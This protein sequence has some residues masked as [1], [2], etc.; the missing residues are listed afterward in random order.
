VESSVRTQNSHAKVPVETK[1]PACYRDLGVV[2]NWRQLGSSTRDAFA[3]ETGVLIYGSAIRVRR[4]T[5]ACRH[6][7]ISNR[8]FIDQEIPIA[9]TGFWS[10][11]ICRKLDANQNDGLVPPCH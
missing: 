8:L 11:F 2:D 6:L 4:N 3:V 10:V 5:S 9:Q 1:V 7:Q